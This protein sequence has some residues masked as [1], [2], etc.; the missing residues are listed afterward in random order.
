[1]DDVEAYEERME[2]QGVV[3]TT[4][5]RDKNHLLPTYI[6]ETVREL[7]GRITKAKPLP[8]QKVTPDAGS[9]T[10][11]GEI[12]ALDSKLTR[13]KSK[14]IYNIQITDYTGSMSL[15]LIDDV[16]QCRGLDTLKVG[17]TI[18][19]RGEIDYDKYDRENVLRVRGLATAEQI[20]VV[21]QAATKRVELH[22][23]TNMSSMDGMTPAGDLIAR[24]H[25]WGHPACNHGSRRGSG[26]SG[27]HKRGQ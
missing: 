19:V 7:Y 21:D 12:F 9:V 6:P 22:L 16:S 2:R 23:H 14:K 26:F 25:E 10:I 5:V 3:R 24:A 27:R 13:D 11:W 17:K 4:Q 8:I 15:K 1:M 20:K 18:L